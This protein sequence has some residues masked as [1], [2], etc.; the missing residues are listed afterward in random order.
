MKADFHYLQ[1]L[2]EGAGIPCRAMWEST[3]AAQDAAKSEGKPWSQP[4]VCLPWERQGR[5]EETAWGCLV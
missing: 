3:S 5:A 2:G 1:F 4:L